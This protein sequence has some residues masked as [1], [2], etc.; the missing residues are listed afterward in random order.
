MVEFLGWLKDEV[1][2]LEPNDWPIVPE[3]WTDPNED[4]PE[5]GGNKT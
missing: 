2:K 1:E 5:D 3:N 4:W